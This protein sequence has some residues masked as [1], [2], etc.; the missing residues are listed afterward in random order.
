[1]FDLGAKEFLFFS[2]LLTTVSDVI[3]DNKCVLSGEL[4]L[5]GLKQIGLKDV[6]HPKSRPAS[7]DR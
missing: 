5:F 7:L 3:S 6:T 4:E 1:V 2:K